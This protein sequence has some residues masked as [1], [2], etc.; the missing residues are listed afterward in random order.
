VKHPSIENLAL[1]GDGEL[2]WWTRATVGRHVRACAQCQR[3]VAAFRDTADA[4]RAETA[5]MPS[6][7][8]WDRLSAEMRANVRV[9]LAA[10]DAISSYSKHLDLGPVQGMSWRMAVLTT[11]VV[12]ML[13][14][15]YW[16]NASKKSERLEAMHLP[17]PVVAEASERGVGMSDGSKEMMLQGPKTNPRA[18]IVTVSTVGSAGAR[19]VDEETGQVTVNHVYVE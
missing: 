4:V 10:S 6:G 13:S 14:I 19:Y 9:G 1:Y 12:V 3:E 15:G 17:D 5:E 2:A 18:A 7:V 11:G 16:L 8:Q